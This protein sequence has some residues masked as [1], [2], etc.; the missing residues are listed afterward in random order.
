MLRESRCETIVRRPA[1][2]LQQTCATRSERDR[3]SDS[4]DQAQVV[5]A[6]RRGKLLSS[7]MDRFPIT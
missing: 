7:K 4:K 2:E 1:L 6:H 3:C 5:P